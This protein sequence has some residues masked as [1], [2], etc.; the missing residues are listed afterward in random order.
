[1]ISSVKREEIQQEIQL[2]VLGTARMPTYTTRSQA[3]LLEMSHWYPHPRIHEI[4]RYKTR[5]DETPGP[6][7][8]GLP[9]IALSG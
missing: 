8:I 9:R 4:E 6:T 3:V 7:P 5:I 2:A 1:V